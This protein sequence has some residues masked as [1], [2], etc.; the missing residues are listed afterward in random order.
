MVEEVVETLKPRYVMPC[1]WDTMI[2]HADAPARM[3]P[4]LDL[5]GMMTAIRAAGATPLLLP[6]LSHYR[7]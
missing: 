4:G 5:S 7:L 1:H 6:M 3:I 2:T